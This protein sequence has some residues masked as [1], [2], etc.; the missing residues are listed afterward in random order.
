MFNLNVK[1]SFFNAVAVNNAVYLSGQIKIFNFR[2]RLRCH[3]AARIDI[4]GY[5]ERSFSSNNA[6]RTFY[7]RFTPRSKPEKN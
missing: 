4:K 2:I 1:D 5:V 7:H 3:Q 6:S